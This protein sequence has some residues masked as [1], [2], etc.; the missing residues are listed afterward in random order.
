MSNNLTIAENQFIQKFLAFCHS[1][2]DEVIDHD[3]VWHCCAIGLFADEVLY[4]PVD[5]ITNEEFN[6][7]LQTGLSVIEC[8]EVGNIWELLNDGN[9]DVINTFRQLANLIEQEL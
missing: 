4:I 2:G 3:M 9:A 7:P 1:K 8:D 6:H 5:E